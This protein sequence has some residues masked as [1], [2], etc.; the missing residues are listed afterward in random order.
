MRWWQVQSRE[1]HVICT[2]QNQ[3][4][5]ATNWHTANPVHFTIWVIF[6]LAKSMSQSCRGI[7]SQGAGQ[8][9]HGF[10]GRWS[11][12]IVSHIALFPLMI[13][14][15]QETFVGAGRKIRLRQTDL[16]VKTAAERMDLG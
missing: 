15:L 3:I 2:H 1:K 13:E 9:Y 11:E 6:K 14:T 12:C 10:I 8:V 5:K 4:A 16:T 7:A